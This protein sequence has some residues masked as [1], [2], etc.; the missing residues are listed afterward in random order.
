MA[1]KSLDELGHL[2]EAIM[3]IVWDMGEATVHQVRDELKKR[4][5]LAYTTVLSAMQKLEKLGWLSHRSEGRIYVFRANR[6]RTEEGQT[7]VK[8]FVDKVFG[9]DRLLLFQQLIND[10]SLANGEL[11]ELKKMIEKKRREKTK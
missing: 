8:K 4:K 10:E 2:Q 9:G 7:S 1:R 6:T 11:Q 3:E 5:K